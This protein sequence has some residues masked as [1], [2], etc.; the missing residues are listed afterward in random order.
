MA[1]LTKDHKPNDIG[2]RERIIKHDGRVEPY[3]DSY[4]NPVGPYRVWKLKDDYPG[5]AMSR[6]F[7]DGVAESLGV[8]ATPDVK[9]FDRKPDDR[10]LII[11]SDG[12]IEFMSNEQI[13]EIIQ[14]FYKNNDCD[15]ATREV[16]K[17]AVKSWGEQEDSIVDDITCIVVFI[18][19]VKGGTL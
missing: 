11:C 19:T 5:L 15:G 2:E 17:A 12:V 9:F 10:A 3:R 18:N 8:V 7:G 14:P 1:A 16:V 4:G 6:S 13:G